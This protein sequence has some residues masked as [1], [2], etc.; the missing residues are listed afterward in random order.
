MKTISKTLARSSVR[1][2]LDR[3]P[4]KPPK[5]ANVACARFSNLNYEAVITMAT[6]TLTRI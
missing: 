5:V 4:T 6:V 2:V 3:L 1:P